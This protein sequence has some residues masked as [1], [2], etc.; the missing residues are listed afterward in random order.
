MKKM[1]RSGGGMK[2]VPVFGLVWICW[3]GF[4]HGLSEE[5]LSIFGRWDGD[6]LSREVRVGR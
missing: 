2:S 4:V 6:V 1:G 3:F 5:G